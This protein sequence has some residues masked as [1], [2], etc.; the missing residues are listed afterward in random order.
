MSTTYRM[1][2]VALEG[3]YAG[4][5]NVPMIRRGDT[6][7]LA[8]I[9]TEKRGDWTEADY[10]PFATNMSHEEREDGWLGSTNNV[11]G[12]ALG[13]GIVV[14]VVG[15]IRDSYDN[16]R[17]H[18]IDPYLSIKVRMDDDAPDTFELVPDG[19]DGYTIPAR[20]NSDEMILAHPE[21]YP[22]YVVKGAVAEFARRHRPDQ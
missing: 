21:E 8:K 20:I 1:A 15:E 17:G 7:F 16:I 6:I 14:A 13:R 19:I 5:E 12:F 10:T 11:D 3:R 4:M 18:A 2:R 9:R 22:A